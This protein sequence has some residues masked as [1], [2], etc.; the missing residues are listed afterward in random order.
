MSLRRLFQ[1]FDLTIDAQDFAHLGV[2]I[3]V[4]TFQ[5]V[6]HLVRLDLMRR[7]NL[8][9]GSLG[10]MSQ[11]GVSDGSSPLTH[12]FGQQS[13]RPDLV[14]IAQILGFAAGQI[15]DE[16]LGFTCDGRLASGTWTVVERRYDAQLSCAPQ[17]PRDR[18]MGHTNRASGRVQR[19]RSAI[20]QQDAGALNVARRFRSR[21]RDPL[22]I[23]QLLLRKRN[24]DHTPRRGHKR[25]S[26]LGKSPGGNMVTLPLQG[27]P[28]NRC[29]SMESFV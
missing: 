26:K 23:N 11:T 20:R 24:V 2:E 6:T 28:P 10:E 7:Q 16:H 27:N 8:A 13:R 15:E 18:L 3:G 1:L 29:G 5:V 19:R 12:V 25:F 21:P 17:T 14:R 22:Q 9:Q 4:A